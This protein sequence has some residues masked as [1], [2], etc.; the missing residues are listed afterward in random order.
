MSKPREFCIIRK[1]VLAVNAQ[2]CPEGC[3]G[4]HVIEYSAYKDMKLK[5]TN[6]NNGIS[7]HEKNAQEAMN[8][9]I[10][11]NERIETLRREIA[12]MGEFTVEV[13]PSDLSQWAN[14]VLRDD[15]KIKGEV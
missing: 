11:A 12:D 4:I 15:N 3:N 6:A 7:F 5:L 10:K 8:A 1:T 9:L 2:D 14:E 13:Y